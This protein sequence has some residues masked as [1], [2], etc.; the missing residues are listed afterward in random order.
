MNP[1]PAKDLSVLATN[2]L[3][4]MQQEQEAL[5]TLYTCFDQQVEALRDQQPDRLEQTT[6]Q[7]NE[8]VH[9]LEKLRNARERQA[10]LLGRMLQVEGEPISLEKIGQAYAL[11]PEG[12]AMGQQILEARLSTRQKAER[13][14]LRC[15]EFEF[16]LQYAARLGQEMLQ[17]IQGLDVPLPARVYTAKGNTT[18]TIPPRSFLNQV[19]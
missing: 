6:H 14:Q 5:D 15:E 13:T 1:T 16:A 18:H 9:Q 19:G 2:L 7:I 4:T 12:T 10:S 17:V 8:V 3:G 11:Q